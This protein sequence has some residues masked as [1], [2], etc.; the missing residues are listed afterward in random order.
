MTLIAKHAQAGPV[1][2]CAGPVKLLGVSD[3]APMASPVLGQRTDEILQDE[4]HLDA[5]T[6]ARLRAQG[7]VQ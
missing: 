5:E 7:V 6:I 2:F 4:L 3:R 1:R